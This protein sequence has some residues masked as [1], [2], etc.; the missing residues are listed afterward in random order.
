MTVEIAGWEFMA[1][2]AC[3]GAG[4]TVAR[5]VIE[6]VVADLRRWFDR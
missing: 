5:L 4:F 2:G 1:I 6:G 3:V